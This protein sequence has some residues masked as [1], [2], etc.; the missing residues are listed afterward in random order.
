MFEVYDF[1]EERRKDSISRISDNMQKK[2]FRIL[3][4]SLN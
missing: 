3:K 1:A 4:N 2:I